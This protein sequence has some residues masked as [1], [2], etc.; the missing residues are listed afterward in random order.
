MLLH[1]IP[2]RRQHAAIEAI[3]AAPRLHA[4]DDA[5]VLLIEVMPVLDDVRACV[6]IL[7]GL[8]TGANKVQRNGLATAVCA[9]KRFP[10]NFPRRMIRPRAGC[11]AGLAGSVAR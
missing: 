10:G 7:V 11:R 4:F 3:G 6:A 8:G 2:V 1:R 5:D 9:G